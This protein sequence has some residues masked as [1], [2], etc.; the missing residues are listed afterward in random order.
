[1]LVPVGNSAAA[2][3]LEPA[4]E[5]ETQE[6]ALPSPGGPA[7]QVPLFDDRPKIIPFESI[8]GRGARARKQS[9]A[10]RELRQNA[11]PAAAAHWAQQPLDLRPPALRQKKAISDD[12]P[13]A[14]PSVRLHAAM[15]DALFTSF[16]IA[17]AAAI[18]YFM[19]GR[20]EF[21][22]KTAWPYAVTGATL[23]VFYQLLWCMLGADSAGMRAA[24]LRVLTFD[25]H[26]PTWRQR[27]VRFVLACFGVVAVGIG[28]LW[29]LIDDE[30]LTWHDHISKTFPTEYDANPSTVRRR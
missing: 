1:M 28:L 7:R 9:A 25:G 20:F 17:A 19:G 29:A 2:P 13:V 16:G 15:L 30:G 4:H 14:N 8:A 11:Q 18:F 22:A 6:Q 26:A 12:V 10:R 27:I 24:G 3:V 23:A 21:S 5:I